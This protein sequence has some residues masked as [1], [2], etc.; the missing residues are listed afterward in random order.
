M[1]GK[2]S[3]GDSWAG[4]KCPGN[5]LTVPV[6][7]LGSGFPA[8]TVSTAQGRRWEGQ[9][10]DWDAVLGTHFEMLWLG[11]HCRCYLSPT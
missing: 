1:G 2:Q 8:V 10:G 7:G 4:S 11:F 3:V 5:E 6:C 9:Q